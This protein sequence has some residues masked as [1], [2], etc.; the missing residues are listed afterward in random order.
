LESGR[1]GH[2]GAGHLGKRGK[3]EKSL[4]D[5][6]NVERDRKGGTRAVEKP[7]SWEKRQGWHPFGG[8]VGLSHLEVTVLG[9]RIKAT[10]EKIME[11]GGG[12]FNLSII[13]RDIG[14]FKDRG[15]AKARR[16][17]RVR[18]EEKG[19]P[20]LTLWWC[21]ET[22]NKGAEGKKKIGGGLFGECVLRRAQTTKLRG[23]KK[24][25]IKRSHQETIR[26]EGGGPRRI[27]CFGIAQ[28]AGEKVNLLGL[29]ENR[30][31][32]RGGNKETRFL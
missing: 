2:R 27:F 12:S 16:F 3:E 26:K 13:C 20:L 25:E 7:S 9:T 8:L 28:A 30:K 19:G 11:R 21:W 24:R 14:G 6:E 22:R 17:L 5:E 15:S 18:G 1:G 4:C 23:K 31:E 32:G 10:K 29:K